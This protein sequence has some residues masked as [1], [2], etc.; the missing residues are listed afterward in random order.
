MNLY[1]TIKRIM[2]FKFANFSEG[3]ITVI[4]YYF[5]FRILINL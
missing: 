4:V 1:D 3:V 5:L 2:L